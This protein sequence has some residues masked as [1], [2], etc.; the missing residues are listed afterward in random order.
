MNEEEQINNWKKMIATLPEDTFFQVMS[1]WVGPIKTPYHKA[2]YITKLANLFASESTSHKIC[3]LLDSLDKSILSAIFLLNEATPKEIYEISAPHL[4][5]FQFSLK[6]INL[7]ERLII[8]SPPLTKDCIAINPFLLPTLKESILSI[9]SIFKPSHTIMENSTIPWLQNALLYAL[10]SVHQ[11]KGLSLKQDNFWKKKTNDK[12]D[13]CFPELKKSLFQINRKE[14]LKGIL[15]N[16]GCFTIENE[17]LNIDVNTWKS[18]GELGV[19]EL[20]LSILTTAANWWLLNCESTQESLFHL[21]SDEELQAGISFFIGL[22]KALPTGNL[23]SILEFSQI[24]NLVAPPFLKTKTDQLINILLECQFLVTYQ[25]HFVGINPIFNFDADFHPPLTGAVIESSF[26]IILNP[27]INFLDGTLIALIAELTHYDQHQ[28]FTITK[29]SFLRAIRLGYTY[30]E[31][32]TKLNQITGNKIPQTLNQNL[33]QWWNNYQR[34]RIIKGT[35]LKLNEQD[36]AILLKSNA[37]SNWIIE[38][39]APGNYLMDEDYIEEWTTTLLSIGIQEIPR[40]EMPGKKIKYENKFKNISIDNIALKIQPYRPISS[41]IKEISLEENP[42]YSIMLEKIQKLN[43]NPQDHER[44]LAKLNKKV[45]IMG[46]QIQPIN[47][48]YEMREA[49]GLEFHG[50][51]AIIKKALETKQDILEITQLSLD[52]SPPCNLIYP[53]KLLK[54][55]TQ[56]SIQGI[57]L[58]DNK[59]YE[60]SVN[61]ISCVRRLPSSLFCPNV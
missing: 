8:Y 35:I 47:F 32:A 13:H 29:D 56:Y 30:K 60:I 38:V 41:N 42:E 12:L 26:N 19:K 52:I 46:D 4:T 23:Y 17:E 11:T 54:E 9:N 55:G 51:L 36:E 50:K 15:I 48:Q 53:K 44:M 61:K 25:K 39:L 1:T 27:N 5:Y 6:L 33:E 58:E 10:L 57:L 45:F 16:L 40:I 59:P 18:L 2:P 37:I 14:L 7:E 3:Q 49:K 28:N 24:L 43:L 22:M 31:I 21:I 20:Y 34:I